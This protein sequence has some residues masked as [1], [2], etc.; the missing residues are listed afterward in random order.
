MRSGTSLVP[1]VT[2][3]LAEGPRTAAFSQFAKTAGYESQALHPSCW[4]PPGTAPGVGPAWGVPDGQSGICSATWPTPYPRNSTSLM[5]YSVRVTS[6]RELR[7]T[8]WFAVD[9]ETLAVDTTEA[10]T[11][12]QELYDFQGMG[13]YDPDWPGANRN[14]IDDARYARYLPA[15]HRLVL[16]YIRLPVTTRA[17]SDDNHHLKYMGFYDFKPQQQHGWTNLGLT[18]YRGWPTP[19]DTGLPGQLAAW[20]RYKIPSLYYMEITASQ[21]KIWSAGVGLVEGWEAYVEKEVAKFRPYFGAGKAIRGV[22]LG[23]EMCCRNVTCWEQYVPYTQQLRTLLGKSAILYTNEW[24]VALSPLC[25]CRSS[26]RSRR[27]C[28]SWLGPK[29][30]GGM[31]QVTI[32]PEFDLFSVDTYQWDYRLSTSGAAEVAAVKG[33]YATLLPLMSPKTQAMIVAGT[34]G[35][36]SQSIIGRAHPVLANGSDSQTQNV[37]A[38]LDG[39]WEYAKSEPRI[40]GF[41]PW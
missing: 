9:G 35:C 5:G 40:A 4:G 13:A 16:G 29:P 19:K 27:V 39:L 12:A 31:G 22:A 8:A 38:K 23:D 15:L 37:L 28:D 14:L 3:P 10:G 36:S 32:A 24:C 41:M 21:A 33:A 2:E 30:A 1:A 17:K 26:H 11:I 34:F 25:R 20:E 7:Y 6:P 18:F